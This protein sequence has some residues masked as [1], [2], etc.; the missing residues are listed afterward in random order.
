VTAQA[1]HAP[2]SDHHRLPNCLNSAHGEG[3]FDLAGHPECSRDELGVSTN[4]EV[5]SAEKMLGIAPQEV[6]FIGCPAAN[7]GT[8]PQRVALGLPYHFLILYRADPKLAITDYISPLLHEL[9]HVYQIKRAGGT[10]TLLAF[11][12]R[13]ELG[14]D[15]LAGIEARRLRLSPGLSQRT[16]DLVGT[17]TN[18]PHGTPEDRTE[19]FRYGYFY[20]PAQAPIGP[21]YADFEDNL[22]NQVKHSG[23]MK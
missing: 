18:D 23:E 14:A 7:F 22:F 17:Y 6:A 3:G 19:A 16:L 15:F 2:Q 9:G 10:G 12:E 8:Q 4:L 20:Q 11:I 13:T 1:Q 21:I 5:R